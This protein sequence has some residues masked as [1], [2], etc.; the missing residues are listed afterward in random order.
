MYWYSKKLNKK[1]Y[2]KHQALLENDAIGDVEFH[3]GEVYDNHDW[4]VEPK[5]S[6]KEILKQHAQKL[7][8]KYRYLRLWYSG[9]SDSQTVLNA[10][11][12]NGI[13]L[14]EIFI[15]RMSPIDDFNHASEQEINQ[16]A[17]PQVRAL[18][19]DNK[20][21]KTKVTIQ[22]VGYKEYK[23][24]VDNHITL[25][26][27]N[28]RSIRVFYPPVLWKL[29]PGLN[30]RDGLANINCIEPGRLGTDDNGVYWYFVDGSLDQDITSPEEDE[31]VKQE[32]FYLDPL[33]HAKQC[34][35]MKHNNKYSKYTVE[36]F[37]YADWYRDNITGVCRDNLFND[38]NLGK[39]GGDFYG[40]AK[41]K[42]SI[43]AAMA[44]QRGKYIAMK[45]KQTLLDTDLDLKHFNNNDPLKGYV[46]MLSKK[47]Y[48]Q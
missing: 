43:D 24:W 33:V 1:Y 14:D 19:N 31:I 40:S 20:I 41:A 45:Y 47:Y 26:N 16:V 23:D 8:D 46:G 30:D 29:L 48:L 4:T 17:I 9:G 27:S 2:F 6:W 37:D 21:P 34:Y 3:M 36:N 35:L 11:V 7:R 32:K 10:F 15:G 13:H 44:D 18:A 22:D 42:M 39:D 38:I 25:E 5:D 28:H 12:D